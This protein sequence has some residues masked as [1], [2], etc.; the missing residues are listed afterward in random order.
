[1]S[2]QS[3]KVLEAALEAGQVSRRMPMLQTC[4]CCAAG[5]HADDFPAPGNFTTETAL[6][7]RYGSIPCNGCADD[8]SECET[9]GKATIETDE[10]HSYEPWDGVHF[11]SHRC[12]DTY[13]EAA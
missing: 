8:H 7:A 13:E 12:R 3:H 1:M 2:I 4:P 11:C 9:C 10:E 6:I 5:L